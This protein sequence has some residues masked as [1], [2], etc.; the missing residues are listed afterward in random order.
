ML[1]TVLFFFASAPLKSFSTYWR[2]T[3]E[4]IIIIII[5]I[6]ETHRHQ[7]HRHHHHI[8]LR[9]VEENHRNTYNTATLIVR[10]FLK[11]FDYT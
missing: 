11:Y 5:I 10:Q 2:Y 8:A 1:I 7:N 3:N 4:I 6:L 9:G